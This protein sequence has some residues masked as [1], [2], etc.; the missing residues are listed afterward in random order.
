[1]LPVSEKRR[2][3]LLCPVGRALDVLGD[4]W[5]LLILRDL[6]AGPARFQELQQ[7]LGVATNL[8]TTR[9]EEL[10]ASG[11]I[12]ERSGQRHEPYR[13]T[14]LGLGTD[15]VLWELVRLGATIDPDPDRQDPGNL[16]AL[17]L[18]LRLM[19]SAVEDR[20]T[21]VVR[22]HVDDEVFTIDSDPDRVDVDYGTTDD[23]P[24]LVI[25]VGY[26]PFIAAAEGQIPLDRFQREH[27][28]VIEG[29][30]RLADFAALMAPA[31]T[32]AD[33]GGPRRA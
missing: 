2:Y 17:A 16:R 28:D 1:M 15:R 8:L 18:P 30:D 13:L 6:H 5:S 14:E 12:A 32:I 33:L 19:L 9:L 29:A 20:P 4:R 25:R 27:V 21:M 7:G 23:Q 26:E 11:L 10:T 22:L 3:R 31:L 24:D